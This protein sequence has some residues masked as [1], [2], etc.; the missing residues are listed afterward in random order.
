MVIAASTIALPAQADT[1]S[2]GSW[3][4]VKTNG[5]KTISG[6]NGVTIASSGG[7]VSG[8]DASPDGTDAF[9]IPSAATS[10]GQTISFNFESQGLFAAEGGSHIA[11]FVS[12]SWQKSNPKIANGYAEGRGIAIGSVPGGCA[13]PSAVIES[14]WKGGNFLF[15]PSYGYNT[16]SSI[17]QD[18][19]AYGI[20]ISFQG[21]GPIGGGTPTISYRIVD[22]LTGA[23]VANYSVRDTASNTASQFAA[24]WLIGTVFNNDVTKN[25]SV[26]FSNIVVTSN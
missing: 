15:A 3:K 17:L 25:W 19:R 12:G 5:L 21:S 22:A 11:V 23:T 14:A 20:T 24:G 7:A 6:P 1:V 16:C 8:D 10:N 2:Y 26:N 18:H 9:G 4:I 13:G